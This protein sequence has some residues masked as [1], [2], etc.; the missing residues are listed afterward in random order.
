[1]SLGEL[2]AIL[3]DK[4]PEYAVRKATKVYNDGCILNKELEDRG[5]SYV[6]K[7]DILSQDLVNTYYSSIIISSGIW[8][9][10]ETYCTCIDFEKNSSKKNYRCKHINSLLISTFL[11]CDNEGNIQNIEKD[12]NEED[13]GSDN[14]L[15]SFKEGIPKL[16]KELV[17]LIPEVEI[18]SDFFTICFRIGK[19]KTYVLKDLKEF[20]LAF[21]AQGEV[22]FGKD[23]TFKGKEHT[24]D[25]VSI[26]LIEFLINELE[27]ETF[28][29]RYQGFTN[30][31]IVKGKQITLPGSKLVQVLSI[32]KNVKVFS[33]VE[34]DHYKWRNVISKPLPLK[35]TLKNEEEILVIEDSVYPQVLTTNFD[36][37]IYN[38]DFY[39]PPYEQ[40]VNYKYLRKRI[41][42]SLNIDESF[43]VGVLESI[44]P[45]LNRITPN[46]EIQESIKK[47]IIEEELKVDFY[48]DREKHITME[49][50]FRYG[51][52]I[53]NPL[54]PQENSKY[55]KRDIEK[56][57]EILDLIKALGLYAEERKF[58]L[59][60]KESEEFVF[61]KNGTEKLLRYGDVYYSDKIKNKG[62]FKEFEIKA[63]I[64]NNGDYFEFEYSLGALHQKEVK[65]ILEA[66]RKGN[67][68]YKMEQGE[69]IDLENEE[70]TK[71]QKFLEGITTGA[72]KNGKIDIPKNKA[73]II[74]HLAKD[75]RID[76]IDGI[77]CIEVMKEKIKS[78]KDYKVEIPEGINAV[79]R[80]YQKTGYRWMKSLE[81]LGFGGI[82]G[83][84]MGLGK[85]LQ[86]ITFIL[87]NKGKK[88][89]IVAPTSLI[90]N[91]RD[92]FQK[93]APML[94]IEILSGSPE[95]REEKL[96]HLDEVD[97]MITSYG[98]LRRDIPIYKE[99]MFNY[100]II[101]E[102]QNIKN[103]S[104]Q[105]AK[106]VKDVKADIRFALTGTPMENSLGE[107]WS[108]FDFL[109]PGYLYSEKKFKDLFD[110]DEE[111]IRKLGLYIKP[112]ILRRR[113][114]EVIL[115]LPD[116]IEKNIIV[117]MKEEQKKVYKAYVDDVR[118][119]MQEEIDKFG[120]SI[121]LLSYLT[122]IRQISLD[123]SLIMDDYDGGSGK[124]EALLEIVEQSIEEGHKI[125]VFSQ[126]TSMLKKISH[127]LNKN[128]IDHY[129]LD[130]A[131]KAQDRIDTVN[132][133]NKDET[134]VFLISLKAGGTGLNLTG[135]DIVIH[136]DPWWNPAVED[137]ATDRA[138]RFGQQNIVEVIK[139][140][141]KDSIEEK[142][143]RL[144]EN[145]KEL[146]NKVLE[147]GLDSGQ[148]FKNLTEKE[149][150]ELF[151]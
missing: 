102:A 80:E 146:I 34:G 19:D 86:A 74:E 21:E 132:K 103:P 96:K 47:D 22:F 2:I 50:L 13:L 140:I 11:D 55:I 120:V 143:V 126:F 61:L 20:L 121:K 23:F 138:H 73:L 91:W 107:L 58:F 135:A 119:R 53:I 89:L 37:F 95:E 7:G 130:G 100:L 94:N 71:L 75:N 27:A 88:S 8:S 60:G 142:I 38:D 129:Y 82:L 67:K 125:L 106:C 127:S 18:D 133:F 62:I 39:L 31:N 15:L 122:K 93:F 65:K 115:E 54:D 70:L 77:N 139:L 141:S 33:K 9:V 81:Y 66:I 118:E 112:F 42:K 12:I 30:K 114:K 79:L 78:L 51:E 76:F 149:L 104:S 4:T 150:I 16:N 36:V 134:P 92:E 87:S 98:T 117:D 1:M 44:V 113:K 90:Y 108:I 52:Y 128:N 105:N 63:K 116:K 14:F 68:Y 64:K 151:A 148:V 6:L 101:D 147:N 29:I 57:R 84:E 28:A 83:D 10:R 43:K 35:F 56:E 32:L 111:S 46:V 144:Q 124:L 3:I 45:F 99:V 97:V 136:F 41:N 85:T 49:T 24:F 26:E 40:R 109:M 110:N 145:K 123:P 131:M 69:F 25:K 137:Q 48:L 59:I 72:E 17:N 5:D